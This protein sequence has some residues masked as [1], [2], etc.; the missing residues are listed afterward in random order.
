MAQFFV[1]VEA[2]LQE[3]LERTDRIETAL[4][5]QQDFTM[6]TFEKAVEA[7][8]DYTRSLKAENELLR[9]DDDADKEAIAAA[10][11]ARMTAEA[12]LAVAQAEIEADGAEEDRLFG[13]IQEVLPTPDEE[14][15]EPIVGD[16]MPEP[17]PE[18]EPMP[19]PETEAEPVAE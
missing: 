2:A 4:Y 8:I 7:L 18:P 5:A 17:E 12:A 9:S 14:E 16:P 10:V 3:L 13:L 11:D 6:A 19:E 1:G 15:E